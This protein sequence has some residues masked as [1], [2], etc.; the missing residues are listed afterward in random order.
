MTKQTSV[1]LLTSSEDLL[2]VQKI[3]AIAFTYPFDPAAY[4]YKPPSGP[5]EIWGC[6]DPATSVMYIHDFDTWFDGHLV[7]TT[8]IGGVASLPEG[9]GK[10]GI[11][12]IFAALLPAWRER[13]VV[14]STLYPFS[15]S[16]YRKFGYELVQKMHHYTLPMSALAGFCCKEPVELVLDPS[17]LL[18]LHR[19]FGA[20][21]NLYV[22]RKESQ[23]HSFD[24][25]PY[26]SLTYTYRVGDRAYVTFRKT[27]PDPKKDLHT[28]EVR[29]L[30]FADAEALRSVFGFLY[31]LRAQYGDVVID[32]P[33]S[34][35]LMDM[36]PECYDVDLQVQQRGMARIV[37]VP[38]ALE[39][40][41]YPQE[42]GAFSV[43]VEDDAL[44]LNAGLYLVRYE[45]GQAVSV[46][47]NDFGGR[48]DLM[49]SVQ[50]LTQLALG[51]LT[52]DQALYRTDVKCLVNPVRLQPIFTRKDIFFTDYF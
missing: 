23:W 29:D 51:A 49:L 4:E 31:A 18:E 14:F 3:E 48:P 33:P 7:K 41:H 28:I 2:Q 8:G 45:D 20:A 47:K 1:R 24:K 17:S 40:M 36:I 37:N 12:E 38:K 13:D 21:H 26:L 6:G 16:F 11:R 39:L 10:G 46:E 35:P 9:R 19:D 50:T 27:H 25:S 22:L 34:V 42:S 52:L 32:L 5:T 43:Q 30:A 44:P 15:H